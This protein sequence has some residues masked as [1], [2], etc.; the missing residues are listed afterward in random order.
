M[1]TNFKN[2]KNYMKTINSYIHSPKD[3]AKNKQQEIEIEKELFRIKNAIK[4]TTDRNWDKEF[5]NRLEKVVI[6]WESI[7]KHIR[8][9][10]DLILNK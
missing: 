9:R 7:L 6:E 2:Y 10:V 4:V 8:S 3:I 5:I 1:L